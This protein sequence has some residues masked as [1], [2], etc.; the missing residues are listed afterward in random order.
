M[1]VFFYIVLIIVIG[2]AIFAIQNSDAKLVIIKFLLWEFE[3]SLVYTIL[4]SVGIGA[5]IIL[6]IWIPRAVRSS[7]QGRKQKRDVPFPE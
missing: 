4:G 7:W 6:L 5:F 3:T 2:I 1:K